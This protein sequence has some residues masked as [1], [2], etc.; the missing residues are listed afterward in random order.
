MRNFGIVLIVLLA[1]SVSAELIRVGIISIEQICTLAL[2]TAGKVIAEL[3]RFIPAD[4][5]GRDIRT[6]PSGICIIG[7]ACIEFAGWSA[8]H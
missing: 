3:C 8:C 5:I 6:S 1:S 7:I 4:I 2:V